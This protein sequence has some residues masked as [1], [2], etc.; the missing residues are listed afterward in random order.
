MLLVHVPVAVLVPVG[1]PV[2]VLVIVAVLVI[3]LVEVLVAVLVLVKVGVAGCG[4]ICSASTFAFSVTAINSI[5][6]APPL[7]LT[8]LNTLSIAILPPPAAAYMSKFVNTCVP[9]ILTLNTLAPALV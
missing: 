9:F 8:L 3:V 6:I 2:L 1:V 7:G 4:I 5:T